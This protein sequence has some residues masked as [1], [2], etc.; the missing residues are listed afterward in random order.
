MLAGRLQRR[1]LV[2]HFV[3]KPSLEAL[4]DRR[5]RIQSRASQR[6]CAGRG[7]LDLQSYF[8]IWASV[9]PRLADRLPRLRRDL[10]L[11]QV[12][13]SAP[14]PVSPGKVTFFTTTNIF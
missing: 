9:P 1:R 12:K 10:A 7:L 11:R 5:C 13:G 6:V 14:A 3:P 4:D 8:P 2:R